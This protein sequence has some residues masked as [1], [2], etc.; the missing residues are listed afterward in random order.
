M[1]KR[2]FRRVNIKNQGLNHKYEEVQGP[3]VQGLKNKWGDATWSSGS[4]KGWFR[5]EEKWKKKAVAWFEPWTSCAL[6]DV[7]TTRPRLVLCLC[8]PGSPCY[9]DETAVY[10]LITQT[11]SGLISLM[12]LLNFM[13]EPRDPDH[14]PAP[15]QGSVMNQRLR[16]SW[17]N[18][19][20]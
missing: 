4:A 16:G 3:E 11:R 1:K 18:N 17:I 2:D 9:T 19:K 13:S 7:R 10:R 20:P 15:N 14:L 8:Y 12:F 6:S 5:K